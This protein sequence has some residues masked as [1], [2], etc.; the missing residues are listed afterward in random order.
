MYSALLTAIAFWI[1]ANFEPSANFPFSNV[2]LVS[3]QEIT[4][5][6]YG[7]FASA[8]QCEVANQEQQTSG[9]LN[10]SQAAAIYD[11]LNET[12]FL[13]DNWKG[14]RPAEL[15]VLVHEMVHHLQKK[16]HL[17][18]ECNGAREEL[19]LKVQKTWLSLFGRDLASEFQIDPF[20]LKVATCGF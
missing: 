12:I 9:V 19:A 11:D 8:Q 2:R 14:D 18:Y 7:A 13:P 15:S 4:F 3:A 17:N 6:R 5:L 16:T 10:R 20:T 1:S